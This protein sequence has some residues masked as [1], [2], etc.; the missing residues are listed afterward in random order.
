MLL[1]LVVNGLIAGCL[2]A[3]LAGAFSV[4]YSASRFFVFTFGASY[5]AA[6]YTLLAGK[7]ALPMWAL[8]PL[9]I[10]MATALGAGLEQGIYRPVRRKGEQPLVLMLASIGLYMIL[11]NLVSL[12]FGDT[13][14]TVRSPTPPVS[15][16]FFGARVTSIQLVI[17]SAAVLLMVATWFLLRHTSFG[18][19]LRAVLGD[20]E[21][22]KT[23]GLDVDHIVLLGASLGSGLAGAAAVLTSQD[24]D[25]V[26]TMGFDAL[27]LG[28]VGAV[29]GGIGTVRGAALGGLLVGL[30]RHVTVWQLPTQWQDG[31]VFLLLLGVLLLRPQGLLSPGQSKGG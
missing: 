17:A 15:L 18:L 25:L 31:I 30:L 28:V 16:E 6:A 21:L 22:A 11:Q 2:V 24:I 13:T 8:C 9:G 1:Q 5:T 23:I 3:L 19:R 26:P 12:A 27:L 4:L 14:Q 7:D 10:L 20:A 29:V